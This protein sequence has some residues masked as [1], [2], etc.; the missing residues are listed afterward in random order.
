MDNYDDVTRAKEAKFI[1]EHP[2]FVG[3]FDAV[4][5]GLVSSLANS[6]LGDVET[7]H[8]I[9]IALQLVEQIER[10]FKQHIETGEMAVIQANEHNFAKL[11][12]VVGF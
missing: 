9:A 10:Q 2:L 7:H 1:L 4:K 3:A 11:K 5:S 8:N 12:R 6:G